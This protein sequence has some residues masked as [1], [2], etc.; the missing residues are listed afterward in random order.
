M[1]YWDGLEV[2]YYFRNRHPGI[3]LDGLLPQSV[4]NDIPS[5]NDKG[6]V[7]RW[8]KN[9]LTAPLQL[10]FRKYCLSLTRTNKWDIFLDY[11]YIKLTFDAADFMY[12]K[13]ITDYTGKRLLYYCFLAYKIREGQN[14]PWH[15][16]TNLYFCEQIRRLVFGTL[17][18]WQNLT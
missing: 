9:T 7:M 8:R 15:S 6:L 16:L 3:Y 12:V 13:C 17:D 1:K 11:C 14:I 18:H 2:A 10:C 4:S 5:V